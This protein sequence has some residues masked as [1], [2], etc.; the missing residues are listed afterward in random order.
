MAGPYSIFISYA[1]E[2]ESFKDQ[3]TQHLAGLKASGRIAP[4]DDRCID[5]GDNWRHEIERA[6]EGCDLALLLL[7]PAFIASDFIRGEELPRLLERR[8]A[9]G[10]R[11]VPLILRPC[12][13]RFEEPLQALQARPTDGKAIVTF[14]EAAGERDQAWLD[15]VGEIHGWASQARPTSAPAAPPQAGPAAGGLVE[16]LRR[17]LHG[18]REALPDEAECRRLMTLVPKRLDDYRAV[19]WAEWSQPRHALDTRF[20]RLTVVLDR[21]P[22]AEGPR[23]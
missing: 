11:V 13:W 19:R 17:A 9:G 12:G 15:I 16:Q 10:I 6:I 4:W 2:D 18:A 7:S 14:A 8:D 3:L 23:W 20:T 21:G 5:G 1:H 22:H